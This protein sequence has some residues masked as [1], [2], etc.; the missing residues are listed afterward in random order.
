MKILT[1]THLVDN[2]FKRT[3]LSRP[4]KLGMELDGGSQGSA[5]NHGQ[6]SRA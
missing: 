2:T 4:V 6:L 5:M 3:K 1:R